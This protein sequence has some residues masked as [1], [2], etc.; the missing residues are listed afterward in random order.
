[1]KIEKSLSYNI[2]KVFCFQFILSPISNF[3]KTIS[4][5]TVLIMSLKGFY[6]HLLK[7]FEIKNSYSLSLLETKYWSYTIKVD[8]N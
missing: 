3:K 5:H 2:E 7:V 8:T 1:M 6:L 4:L